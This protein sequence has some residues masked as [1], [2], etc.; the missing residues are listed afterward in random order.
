[1]RD[2][3]GRRLLKGIARTLYLGDLRVKRAVLGMSDPPRYRLEGTCQGCGKCCES[4]S[5]QV[6]AVIWYFRPFRSVFV[7][8]QF[9]VNGFI[10]KDTERE[11]R[12]LIF[13]CTH[14]DPETRQCDSYDSRPGMCR[15]YPRGLIDQPWPEFFEEC[16]IRPISIEGD[17]LRLVLE[18]A[19]LTDEQR[20][21]LKK[22]LFLE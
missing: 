17:T 20:E 1:M 18:N 16:T 8:W 3:P 7:W 21:T 4:P 11:G 5:I 13:S 14:F 6:N 10:L 2:G 22:K 19:E 15:D 12:A 9:L